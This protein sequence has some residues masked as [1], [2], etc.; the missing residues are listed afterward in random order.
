MKNSIK[1]II[2]T[3]TSLLILIAVLFSILSIMDVYTVTESV[4]KFLKS[5]YVILVI[6]MGFSLISFITSLFNKN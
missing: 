5:L 2:L 4:D 6:V 3:A 1:I